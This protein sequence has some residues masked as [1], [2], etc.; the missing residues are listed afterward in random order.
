MRKYDI[1]KIAN[2]IKFFNINNVHFLGKTKLMKL[3]F[4]ADKLH[5]QKFGRPIFYDKYFKLPHGPVPS[6]TLNII[7]S[8]NE[9]ENYDLQEYTELFKKHIATKEKMLDNGMKQTIFEIKTEFDEEAFSKSEIEIL[10]QVAKMFK[11]I[12]AKQISEISHELPEYKY[13]EVNDI[14]DYA[15]MA[16]E[17]KE[18]IE[19]IEKTNKELD[20]L[21]Q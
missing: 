11:D 14:I 7:D 16:P 8:L 9:E 6:L 21:L 12:N 15:D 13:T 3:L 18:Y 20:H 17:N 4:F 19:F 2:A 5:L 1:E 10:T